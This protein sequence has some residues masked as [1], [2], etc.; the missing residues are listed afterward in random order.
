VATAAAAAA[1]AAVKRTAKESVKCGP[2]VNLA[3]AGR[4]GSWVLQ[5]SLA[6]LRAHE[7]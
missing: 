6:V 4:P 3:L 2:A 5:V 1:A 7:Q